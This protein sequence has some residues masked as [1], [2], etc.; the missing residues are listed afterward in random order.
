[1]TLLTSKVAS[2]IAGMEEPGTTT[3]DMD[4]V[5]RSIRRHNPQTDRHPYTVEDVGKAINENPIASEAYQR[6]TD[7]GY[8]V[9]INHDRPPDSNQMGL[10]RKESNNVEIWEMNNWNKESVIGTMVHESVH[11]DFRFRKRI[12]N[13]TRYEEFR[14]FVREEMYRNSINSQSTQLRPTL[15]RRYEIWDEVNQRYP[16]LDEGKYPFGGA[17]K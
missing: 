16:E 3:G 2:K 7:Q 13:N 5:N 6:I 1:M 10:T 8:N 17:R 11:V 14:A 15:Q 9:R 12:R 4:D